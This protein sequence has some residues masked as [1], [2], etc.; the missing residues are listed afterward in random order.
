MA[1]LEKVAD[2]TEAEKGHFFEG[3]FMPIFLSVVL[4]SCQLVVF[5]RLGSFRNNREGKLILLK[6]GANLG[7]TLLEL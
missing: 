7:T 3:S 2:F 5:L 4:A 1:G 6:H